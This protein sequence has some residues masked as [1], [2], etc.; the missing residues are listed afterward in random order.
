MARRELFSS[1][2]GPDL[3]P[4][5]IQHL[6]LQIDCNLPPLSQKERYLPLDI[7]RG[8]ALSGV[9]LVNLLTV[10]RVSLFAHITGTDTASDWPDGLVSAL[11][12]VLLEFKAFTLFSF[13]FGVG[14]AIQVEHGSG[15]TGFL[16]RRFSVLLG[17]G[18]THVLLVWN[19]DI[20]TLYAICGFLLIPLIR[21]PAPLVA[22][23]GGVLLFC[24]I[25]I[26]FPDAHALQAQAAE[27]TKVYASGG[28]VEILGFR[29]RETQH[30]I[31][32]LMVLALPRALGV[33]LL[34]VAA[35][36]AELLTTRR[37]FW[38]P[39]LLVSGAIGIF[40]SVLH[41]DLAATVPL[42]FAYAAAV[43]LWLPRSS[44]LAAGGQMALTNYLAQSV[45]FSFV[46]YGY[47]LGYFGRA[48]VLPTAVGGLVF[49]SAQ[50][51]FSRWWLSHFHF[52]PAEWLWRSLS[53]GQLQP[54]WRG[55][56][57][58][59][60]HRGVRSMALV[61]TL[62]LVPLVHLGLPWILG[63]YGPHWGWTNPRTPGMGNYA[64][65]LLLGAGMGLLVWILKATL[66]EIGNLPERV[67]LG[68]RP[69]R[70]LQTGPYAWMRH[71]LYTAEMLLW[72]GVGFYMGS[73][74]VLA[75]LLVGAVVVV[76]VVIPK[77]EADLE[78]YFG[79]EYRDYRRRLPL[80]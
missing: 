65:F 56:Q 1:K 63:N 66:R 69:A 58:T 49:Y 46:F 18:L 26:P 16:L 2:F 74:S 71:P 5:G 12:S 39:I 42:A 6:Q 61:V 31:F 68:L 80:F 44:L 27:A 75:V 70:L 30:F 28:F 41:M 45:V 8:L 37:K 67:P 59:L 43:L 79:D 48:G 21:L 19:G 29:W 40:G 22:F 9:L 38:K 15:S 13:L 14:V 20:L 78:R 64:G 32:P 34:G 35:W 55:S 10:F 24:S 57:I 73:P 36:R 11:M 77:E 23:V 60:S 7:L 52:G 53:Y 33:M 50:L 25:P 62:F 54:L 3:R 72:M 17:I 51:I 4:L 76:A 47:G